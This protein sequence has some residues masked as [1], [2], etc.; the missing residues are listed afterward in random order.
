MKDASFLKRL[1]IAH[2][3]LHD[4]NQ[5]CW[6]NTLPAFQAAVDGGFGIELDVQL[7]SDGEALVFHDEKL[8]RLTGRDGHIHE[9]SVAE[10]AG[11]KIG[12]TADTIPTLPQVLELIGGTVPVVIELKGNLGHDSGLAA[13]VAKALDSYRGEA[14]I[15]SFAHWHVRTFAAQAPGVVCGLTAEGSRPG[16]MESHFSMLAHG[17]DFVSYNVDELPNPF[18]SFVRGRLAMPVITWTVRDEAQVARTREHADQMTFE[19]FRPR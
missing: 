16:Q 18:V 9:L 2:R 17:L 8:E 12:G 5:A 3:G 10:A 19:G 6:E 4:G 13:V 1:P 7:S 11:T 14:A 15:M